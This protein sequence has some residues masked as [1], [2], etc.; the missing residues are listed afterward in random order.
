MGRWT[1]TS[2]KNRVEDLL[3][4]IIIVAVDRHAHLSWCTKATY[5]PNAVPAPDWAAELGVVDEDWKG[6]SIIEVFNINIAGRFELPEE[7]G[8]APAP[9]LVFSHLLR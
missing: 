4:Q 9:D 6:R 8:G 5:L 1:R 2:R 7:L 3:D